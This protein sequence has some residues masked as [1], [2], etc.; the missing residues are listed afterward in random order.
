M[1]ELKGT[2]LSHSIDEETKTRMVRIY[3]RSRSEPEA[4]PNLNS[5]SPASGLNV[6]SLKALHL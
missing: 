1:L 3:L 4:G 2:N 6:L 5:R